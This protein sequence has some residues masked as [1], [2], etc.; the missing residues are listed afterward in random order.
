MAAILEI[1]EK[2][3]ANR[4]NL[5]RSILF[6]AFS[7]EE[8]GLLGSKY[9]TKNPLIDLKQ[10]KCMLNLDTIGRLNPETKAVTVG[11]TGTAIG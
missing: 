8:M 4:E 11:G 10:V 5:K 9:F 3:E 6:M 1:I 7:A 2:L